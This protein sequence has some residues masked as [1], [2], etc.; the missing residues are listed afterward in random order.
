MHFT[1]PAPGW[2]T[3]RLAPTSLATLLIGFFV[4]GC[5]D[6]DIPSEPGAVIPPLSAR[7]KG[8]PLSGHPSC[9]TDSPSATT[10]LVSIS[11]SAG[12]WAV[13]QLVQSADHVDWLHVFDSGGKGTRGKPKYPGKFDTEIYLQPVSA[14]SIAECAGDISLLGKLNQTT[15]ADRVFDFQVGYDIATNPTGFSFFLFRWEDTDGTFAVSTGF[16]SDGSD[17]APHID[18]LGDNSEPFDDITSSAI[19]RVFRIT[20]AKVIVKKL[21]KNKVIGMLE[22]PNDHMIEVTVAPIL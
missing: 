3:P 13:D 17:P 9:K 20:G 4:A 1:C 6:G 15:S 19:T 2:L 11:S 18:F 14:A 10:F 7:D 21:D 16:G 8:C 22:C 12:E 5:H